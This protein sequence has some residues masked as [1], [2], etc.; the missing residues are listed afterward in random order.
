MVTSCWPKLT[1]APILAIVIIL[2]IAR[3]VQVNTIMIKYS[4]ELHMYNGEAVTE[5]LKKEIELPKPSSLSQM[6]SADSKS[7]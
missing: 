3:L 5:R 4:E 1:R 6:L 2:Q 7:P